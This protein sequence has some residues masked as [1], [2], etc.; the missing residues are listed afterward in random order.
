MVLT[1]A[2]VWGLVGGTSAGMISLS[3][4]IASAKPHWWTDNGKGLWPRLAVAAIG[5]ALGAIVAGA[6]HDQL[7]GEWPALVIG[8]SAPSVL[9]GAMSRVEVTERRHGEGGAG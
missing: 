7:A 2:A 6:N 3:T 1:D 5:L 8:A 9:R 4:A